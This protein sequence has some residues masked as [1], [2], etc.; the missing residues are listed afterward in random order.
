MTDTMQAR[1]ET[2]YKD[3]EST[4]SSVMFSV[5]EA[6]AMTADALHNI[7]Q[8][9]TEEIDTSAQIDSALQNAFEALSVLHK[10]LTK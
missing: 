3:A 10:L 1:I 9:L 8:L 6:T 4:N 5:E 7:E 2:K